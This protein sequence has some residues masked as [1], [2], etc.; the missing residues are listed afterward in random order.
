MSKKIVIWLKGIKNPLEAA[1]AFV[2]G[3]MRIVEIRLDDGS[4]RK[5][6]FESILY[7]DVKHDN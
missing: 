5:I 1:D 6:P 3:E 4:K 7:F 2:D